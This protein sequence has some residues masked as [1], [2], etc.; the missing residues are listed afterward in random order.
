MLTLRRRHRRRL[1][2]HAARARWNSLGQKLISKREGQGACLGFHRLNAMM[3]HVLR[4]EWGSGRLCVYGRHVCSARAPLW[5]AACH[6][7]RHTGRDDRAT[8]EQVRGAR[9]HPLTCV[10]NTC[11]PCGSPPLV[12]ST[13][14]DSA[15][16]GPADAHDP[17]QNA[18]CRVCGHHQRMC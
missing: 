2:K 6:D 4:G 10:P 9:P 11:R 18:L 1:Q 17:L 12:S 16:A 5:R 14:L 3:A 7:Y 13:N 8:Q 15:G